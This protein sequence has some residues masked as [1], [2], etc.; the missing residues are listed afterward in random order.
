MILD[1]ASVMFSFHLLCRLQSVHNLQLNQD[2]A[3]QLYI[4]KE[5]IMLVFSPSGVRA[6]Q[7]P[8]QAGNG[9]PAVQG[10]PYWEEALTFTRH[11]FLQR[12]VEVEV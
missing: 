7:R 10:E 5:G 6:P 8:Q 3:M 11:N 2:F 9:R 12:D 1:C 4:E